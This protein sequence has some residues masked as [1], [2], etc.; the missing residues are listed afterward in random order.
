MFTEECLGTSTIFT[1]AST[2]TSGGIISGWEWNFGDGAGTSNLQNPTYTYSTFGTFNVS[3]VVTS[4]NGCTDYISK[5]VLVNP[6]PEAD[7]LFS[8]EC[9][10]V[11]TSFFD[12]SSIGSG[13]IVSWEW[14]FGD[15]T[16]TSNAQNP[17][18]TYSSYGIYNVQLTVTSNTGCDDF[19]YKTVTVSP[20]PVA[21]FT[22]TVECNGYPTQFTDVSTVATGTI[23][24]WEWDFGD[25]VGISDEQNPNY[26]YTSYGTF[27]VELIVASDN[28]CLDIISKNVTVLPSPNADFTFSVGCIGTPSEFTD[29]STIQSGSIVNWEWDFGDGIGTSDEQNPTYTY[30]S[31]GIYDVELIVTANNNCQDTINYDVTVHPVPAADFTFTEVCFGT[32]TEFFDASTIGSGNIVNWEWD[33]GVGNTVTVQNPTHLYTTSG[34][35]NV[36]LTVVSDSGC[37]N[38]VNYDINV[39]PVPEAQFSFTTVCLGIPTGFTDE[40]SVIGEITSWTWDFGDDSTSMETNPSHTYEFA[41]TYNVQLIVATEFGC[42]DTINHDVVVISEYPVSVSILESANDICQNEEVTFTAYPQNP[43]D[44]PVYYWLIN[45][46]PVDTTYIPSITFETLNNNDMVSCML[47][48]SYTCAINNPATSLAITM[49][50]SPNIQ[51]GFSILSSKNPTC[52]NETVIFSPTNL[53]NEGNEPIFNWYLNGSLQVSQV[54]WTTLVENEDIITAE[55]ESNAKCV[56]NSP[57]QAQDAITMVVNPS[58]ALLNSGALIPKPLDNPVVLICMDSSATYN[59]QWYENGIEIPGANEQFYY[60]NKYN[61][62]FENGNGYHVRIENEFGCASSSNAYEY[63]FNKSVLFKESELFIVYPNPSNGSF[64]LDLNEEIIP[65]NLKSFNLTISDMAGKVKVK[66]EASGSHYQFNLSNLQ[67]GVYLLHVDIPQ[68]S[69]QFKKLVIK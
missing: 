34:V 37:I 56:T 50:V 35:H 24:S 53:V 66:S 45:L 64:S 40:S 16:G 18:Y 1:D 52:D 41:G 47:K 14:D 68:F 62:T 25:G 8:D 39:Y 27:S 54:E 11:A 44:E 21:D 10:G 5:N 67:K 69:G 29:A 22:Y 32:P 15:G 3:L 31:F 36:L 63:A 6:V 9:E 33:F 12:L 48:S 60:P 65:E 61:L 4:D 55:L 42:S 58:P 19:I 57:V 13:S 17:F 28:N 51:A 38:T 59:Y 43:G 46:A 26:T 2:I 20:I 30:G 49:E 7:F 23:D